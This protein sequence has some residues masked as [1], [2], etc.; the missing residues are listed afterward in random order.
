VT[1]R[2]T[3]GA[4]VLTC[5]RLVE[6]LTD[7]LEGVLDDGEAQRVA[8]HVAGCPDCE[9]YVEQMRAMVASLGRLPRPELSPAACA[10]LLAAFHARRGTGRA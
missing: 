4:P 1:D 10:E 3:T 7:Y 8:E 6:L 9:L 2:G 5:Q